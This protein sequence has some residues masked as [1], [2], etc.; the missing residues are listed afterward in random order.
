[1]KE[2]NSIQDIITDEVFIKNVDKHINEV[3]HHIQKRP[4]GNYKRQ[5]FDR[6]MD[7]DGLN[8]KF[9][10]N[11]FLAISLKRSTLSAE[12]RNIIRSACELSIQNTLIHY[13]K[14]SK[15]Q[16]EKEDVK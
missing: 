3:K 7:V 5:W 8:P 14:Q 13:S 11:N 9:F 10:I 15:I 2:F 12:L 16:N 6:L 1:M 4:S